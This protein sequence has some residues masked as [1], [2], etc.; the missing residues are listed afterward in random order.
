MKLRWGSLFV[1]DPIEDSSI[2]GTVRMLGLEDLS[3]EARV[4]MPFQFTVRGV[5]IRIAFDPVLRFFM[6]TASQ[7]GAVQRPTAIVDLE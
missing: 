3:F 1:A 6:G 5:S 4:D 2:R 7:A